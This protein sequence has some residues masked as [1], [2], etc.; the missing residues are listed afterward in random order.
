[1]DDLR[2]KNIV[3]GVQDILYTL[4]WHSPGVSL[5]GSIILRLIS[6]NKFCILVVRQETGGR[7][8]GFGKILYFKQ[9][10]GQIGD[11]ESC[12]GSHCYVWSYSLIRISFHYFL[13]DGWLVWM[14]EYWFCSGILFLR[15]LFLY[16]SQYIGDH[17]GLHLF[18]GRWKGFY[19]P[20]YCVCQHRYWDY[21]LAFSSHYWNPPLAGK[22]VVIDS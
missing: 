2:V 20:D 22:H 5:Y 17:S 6:D 7:H 16:C 14:L 11:S 1:M 10:H 3:C 15:M 19:Y 9:N 13:R 8:N 18:L 4:A 12:V 21:C